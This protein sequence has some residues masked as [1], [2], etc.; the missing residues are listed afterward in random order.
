MALG[1]QHLAFGLLLFW[2][3]AFTLGS[4]LVILGTWLSALGSAIGSWLFDF[5]APGSRLLAFGLGSCFQ[6]S[7]LGSWL[8]GLCP[9]LAALGSWF[10]AHDFAVHGSRLVACGSWHFGFMDRVSHCFGF[11][12]VLGS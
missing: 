10:G 4:W 11:F 2:L 5:L 9:W 7:A 6:L 1:S 12:F 8:S 3:L